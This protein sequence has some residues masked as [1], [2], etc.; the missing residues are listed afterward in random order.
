MR[1]NHVRKHPDT[2]E[3]SGIFSRAQDATEGIPGI[4]PIIDCIYIRT[5]CY[6]ITMIGNGSG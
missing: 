6:L 5:L 2:V 3:S 4:E 1:G